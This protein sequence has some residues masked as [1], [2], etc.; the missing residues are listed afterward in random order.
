MVHGHCVWLL[1]QFDPSS[2]R[3]EDLYTCFII[4]YTWL[5][6][7]FVSMLWLWLQLKVRKSVYSSP[8]FFFY[9]LLEVCCLSLCR[10]TDALNVNLKS[11]LASL[12]EII[13]DAVLTSLP[14]RALLPCFWLMFYSSTFF[15]RTLIS[16]CFSLMFWEHE[17]VGWGTS[18]ALSVRYAL[19]ASHSADDVRRSR[20][21]VCVHHSL[22]LV[23]LVAI[24]LTMTQM[25]VSKKTNKKNKFNLFFSINFMNSKI[26]RNNKSE[27]GRN[28][29]EGEGRVPQRAHK[30]M[31]Q[32]RLP[33]MSLSHYHVDRSE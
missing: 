19:Q 23:K 33:W 11:L 21:A 12:I 5:L 28:R 8:I 32:H 10:T 16:R 18:S 1:P 24:K 31:W 13:V 27:V 2:N 26:T 3:F 7:V 4:Q 20:R 17:G 9:F 15:Q 25:S 22:L 14:Q 6:Y 29:I 30:A